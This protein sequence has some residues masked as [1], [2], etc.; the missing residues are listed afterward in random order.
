MS[1]ALG[2]R[3]YLEMASLPE[4]LLHETI[5]GDCDEKGCK[6]V[7]GGQGEEEAGEVSAGRVGRG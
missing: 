5:G 3:P 2:A 4:L 7:E 6:E 1:P